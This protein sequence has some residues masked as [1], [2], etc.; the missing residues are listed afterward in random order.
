V[1]DLYYLTVSR[2]AA[3]TPASIHQELSCW[4]VPVG[5]RNLAHANWA[6]VQRLFNRAVR[7]QIWTLFYS[8]PLLKYFN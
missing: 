6:A 4:L 5:N 1:G 2:G 8:P 7:F 3:S